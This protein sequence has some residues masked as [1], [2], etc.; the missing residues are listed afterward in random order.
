ML[1]SQVW[2]KV[3]KV[4]VLGSQKNG[5]FIS[6]SYQANTSSLYL[7]KLPEDTP[8]SAGNITIIFIIQK[9]ASNKEKF[10]TKSKLLSCLP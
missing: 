1:R 8:M 6:K 10:E 7:S 4:K 3:N 2:W 9:F 5:F